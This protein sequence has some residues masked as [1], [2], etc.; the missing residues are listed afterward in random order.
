VQRRFLEPADD[1]TDV[2][3]TLTI[4]ATINEQRLPLSRIEEIRI[5]VPVGKP[6]WWVKGASRNV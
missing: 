4:F 1:H 3:S 6:E 5:P 2:A